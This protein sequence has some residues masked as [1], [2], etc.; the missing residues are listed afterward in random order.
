MPVLIGQITQFVINVLGLAISPSAVL[1]G[2]SNREHVKANHPATH[3][4][5]GDALESVIKGI[6]ESPHY[7]GFRH[8]AIEYIKTMPDGEI[9]KVAVRASKNNVYFVRTIYPL[10][11]EE[12][13]GFLAMKTLIKV[14]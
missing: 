8:S 5:Y 2:D 1:W 11:Q 10:R 14:G 4:K 9:L 7:V 6:L 13:D 12:L 3:Q